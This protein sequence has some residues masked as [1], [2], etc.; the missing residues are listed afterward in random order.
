M[1]CNCMETFPRARLLNNVPFTLGSCVIYLMSRDQRVADN[2]A[3]FYAQQTALRYRLPL[4]VVFNL[5]S[6]LGV[7]LFEHFVFMLQGLK[8]IENSLK[9]KNIAFLLTQGDPI[10]NMRAIERKYAPLVWFADASPLR[11]PRD[12]RQKLA[13]TLSAPFYEVDT[14][15]IVPVWIT[16][17]KK[18][19]A[20]YTLRPKLS[21]FLPLWLT[22]P[23]QILSHPFSFSPPLP[24]TNW[25]QCLG[26]I[27]AQHC[28]TY[29]PPFIPGEKAASVLMHNFIE[30]KLLRY[31]QERNNIAQDAQSN[32]SP[33]FHFGMLAPLRV[34]LEVNK[35]PVPQASKQVFLEELIIRRELAENYC[36]YEKQYDSLA[37]APQWAQETLKKHEKDPREFV[38]TRDEFEQGLTHD[39]LWNAAQNELIIKGKIHGY[40][41]MYWAKKIL[42]WTRKPADALSIALYL[43]DRYHLDGYEP[44]G[45]AGIMWSIA[46]VHDRPWFERPIFGLIRSMTRKSLEKKYDTKAYINRV[47]QL[48]SALI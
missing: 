28:S 19:W 41:R 18:E 20:A 47:R 7:R 42:E 23:P 31:A 40:M 26:S 6:H 12:L 35:A 11:E 45:Y 3:L 15:N 24:P 44:S 9:S 37:A 46:G 38:Y 8:E 5:L 32:L 17:D 39:E 22:E 4:L 34:A 1:A 10:N 13:Q 48:Q 25:N 33:Y 2:Y 21:K 43:N 30:Q 29:K 16:S 27:K 14:H 36:F